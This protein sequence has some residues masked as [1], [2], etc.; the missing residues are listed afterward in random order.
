MSWSDEYHDDPADPDLDDSDDPAESDMDENDDPE[1]VACP[2]CGAAVIEDAEI[3]PR[4]GNYMGGGDAPS[5]KP[6][7]ILLTVIALLVAFAIGA[8]WWLI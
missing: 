8:L 7:W 3:C 2:F 1:V 4:C 5:P 6:K